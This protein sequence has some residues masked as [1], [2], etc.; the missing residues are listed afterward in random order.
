MRA[1]IPRSL[2][3]L[4][5]GSADVKK[6]MFDRALLEAQPF[7]IARLKP[8]PATVRSLRVDRLTGA[9]IGDVCFIE[10]WISCPASVTVTC[11]AVELIVSKRGT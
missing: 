8:G 11:P 4:S 10:S 6:M 1:F 3:V 2:L 9:I 5:K 7:K